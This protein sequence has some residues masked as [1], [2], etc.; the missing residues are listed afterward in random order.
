MDLAG[1][2][3]VMVVIGGAHS[4]NTQELVKTCSQFCARVHHVQT[5]ADLRE[6]WF[7]AHDIIG[8]T[9][10]TSTPDAAI[11]GEAVVMAEPL[12]KAGVRGTNA[13]G[14]R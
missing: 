4:N 13:C 5:A 9:A 1:R 8:V 12:S 2:C 3:E 6:E 11:G 14:L 7:H 10:G